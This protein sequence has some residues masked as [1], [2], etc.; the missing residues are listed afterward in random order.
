VTYI[1]TA[2]LRFLATRR[3]SAHL[4]YTNVHYTF[5]KARLDEIS[6][7]IP[8]LA[9]GLNRNSVRLGLSLLLPVVG[10]RTAR[11]N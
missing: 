4:T 5:D 1:S 10:P 7:L 8:G 11:G 9:S 2:D 6:T 3:W